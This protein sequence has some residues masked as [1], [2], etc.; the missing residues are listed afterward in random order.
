MVTSLSGWLGPEQSCGHTWR[1]VRHWVTGDSA[2]VL[3]FWP[4]APLAVMGWGCLAWGDEAQSSRCGD[5]EPVSVKAL[6][7]LWRLLGNSVSQKPM[8]SSAA[9]K[10]IILLTG[11]LVSLSSL[12]CCHCPRTHLYFL[13]SVIS[14]WLSPF[15][16]RRFCTSKGKDKNPRKKTHKQ[17]LGKFL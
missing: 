11:L 15:V 14:L 8:H 12:I 16:S 7:G 4:D 1:W 17:K 10:D 9:E 6:A 5:N 2:H 3:T 13:S